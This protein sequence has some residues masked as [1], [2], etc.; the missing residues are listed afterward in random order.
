MHPLE[1]LHP[2]D[3]TRQAAALSCVPPFV[4]EETGK[5]RALCISA[6][7]HAVCS[8]YPA[9]VIRLAVHDLCCKALLQSP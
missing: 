8:C 2:W 1:A 6:P 7:N 5:Q 3:P 9:R 4:G